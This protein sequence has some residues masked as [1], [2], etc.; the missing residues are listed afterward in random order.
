M[1]ASE[2][3]PGMVIVGEQEEFPKS[4][5]TVFHPYKVDVVIFVTS[6]RVKIIMHGACQHKANR[7]IAITLGKD[8]LVVSW[9]EVLSF[10]DCAGLD[11]HE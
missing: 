5:K 11:S 4:T 7:R 8:E 10:N 1:K 9:N 2:V 3:T 6:T